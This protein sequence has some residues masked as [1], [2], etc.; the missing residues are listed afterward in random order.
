LAGESTHERASA[1]GIGFRLSSGRAL[2][3]QVDYGHVIDASDPQQRGE[4][5]LHAQ[6]AL[7]Y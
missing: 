1:A 6:L 3:L 5:R 7:S 4:Q 2:S